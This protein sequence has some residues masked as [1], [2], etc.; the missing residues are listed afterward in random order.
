MESFKRFVSIKIWFL[1]AKHLYKRV[2]IQ[3]YLEHVLLPVT[4]KFKSNKENWTVN[5]IQN[6]YFLVRFITLETRT[7][8]VLLITTFSHADESLYVL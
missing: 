7:T 1:M 3:K 5:T 6:K 4:V 8:P 2:N